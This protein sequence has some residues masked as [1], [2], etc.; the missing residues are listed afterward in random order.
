MEG[1]KK[2]VEVVMDEVRKSEVQELVNG[3]WTKE[4]P[5]STEGRSMGATVIRKWWLERDLKIPLLLTP[6]LIWMSGC[7]KRVADQ[8][9]VDGSVCYLS[10][11]IFQKRFGRATDGPCLNRSGDRGAQCFLLGKIW[12]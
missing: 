9:W 2:V 3:N 10:S 11:Q 8:P 6:T 7:S 5:M 1:F 4:R 12:T